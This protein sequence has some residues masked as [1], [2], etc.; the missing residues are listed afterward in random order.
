[1]GGRFDLWLGVCRQHCD[2]YIRGMRRFSP[3]CFFD[4]SCF[5]VRVK[6]CRRSVDDYFYIYLG[7]KYGFHY[8]SRTKIDGFL[9]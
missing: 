8:T 3:Q 1:M 5:D 4:I 7:V 6:E 9:T 2:V